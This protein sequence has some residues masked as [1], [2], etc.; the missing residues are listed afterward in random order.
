MIT[1]NLQCTCGQKLA[2]DV[3]PGL[4]K[5]PWLVKCPTCG[6]DQTAVANEL[7]ARDFAVQ[8]GLKLRS[9]SSESSFAPARPKGLKVGGTYASNPA[10]IRVDWAKAFS[11]RPAALVLGGVLVPFGALVAVFLHPVPGLVLI[12]AAVWMFLSHIR[13]VRQKFWAGDV[14]PG[15]VLS[16]KL[17]AV[18]TNMGVDGARRP[19]L[20]VMWYPLK[21]MTGG[22]PPIGSR[23]ATLALYHGPVKEGAWKN[24]SPEVLACWVSDENEI[25]RVTDSISEQEWRELDAL[26]AQ[27][28]KPLAGFYK[29]WGG[30]IGKVKRANDPAVEM[31]LAALIALAL[32]APLTYGMISKWKSRHK[33]APAAANVATQAPAEP[34]PPSAAAPSIPTVPAVPAPAPTSA[35]VA[36][37]NP[38]IAPRPKPAVV[39][40]IDL[41]EQ[42]ATFTNLQGKAFDNVKLVRAD[43]KGG[44]VYS[45][46]GGAGSIPFNTLPAEFLTGIGIPT[47]WPGVISAKQ[48]TTTNTVA[49]E[50][51]PARAGVFEVGDR[52]QVIWAGTWEPAVILAF[53]N[54]NI[55]VRFTSP[56]T[57]IHN[58][59]YVPT[60]W[61][62]LSR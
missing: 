44:L 22:L 62:R 45:F 46:D 49:A 48:T 21:K 10:C 37:A 17:V 42:L 19:A 27:I 38:P 8:S 30:H 15:I 53:R 50:S 2:F 52:V 20:K 7:I 36:K 43:I 40:S 6:A 23:V 4:G 47:N 14:C 35:V 24:F 13:E 28:P 58:E 18:M 16:D 32:F 60:N 31:I 51:K 29:M 12:F 26:L 3:E 33:E 56:T 39:T 25:Q 5:M 34:T 54:R 41:G 11:T 55:V 59:L 57:P 61:V 1:L 9:S